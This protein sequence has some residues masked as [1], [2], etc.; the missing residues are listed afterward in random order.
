MFLNEATNASAML[1]EID[2]QVLKSD[3]KVPVVQEIIK[4]GKKYY[5]KTAIDVHYSGLP[6]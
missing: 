1:V 3:E 6:I 5:T 4:Y 2:Q